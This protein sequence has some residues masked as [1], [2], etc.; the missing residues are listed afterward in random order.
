MQLL[1]IRSRGKRK[2]VGHIAVTK[3]A[4]ENIENPPTLSEVCHKANTL[5]C[6]ICSLSVNKINRYVQLLYKGRAH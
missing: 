6:L 5:I 1:T 3:E 4:A 2:A